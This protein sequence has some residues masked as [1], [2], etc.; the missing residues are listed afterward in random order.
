MHGT[1]TFK[2]RASVEQVD[3][4]NNVSRVRKGAEGIETMW[5]GGELGVAHAGRHVLGMV[6]GEPK[7]FASE[8]ARNL[9]Y[10]GRI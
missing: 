7:S 10:L 2:G 1:L 6:L 8:A 4:A 9:P 5:S 3:L